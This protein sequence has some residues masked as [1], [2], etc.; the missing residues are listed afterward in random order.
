MKALNAEMARQ[1][2]ES[3]DKAFAL[4]IE[5]VQKEAETCLRAG[6]YEKAI[7]LIEE[8]EG[9]PAR[10]AGLLTKARDLQKRQVYDKLLNQAEELWKLVEPA[11]RFVEG[12]RSDIAPW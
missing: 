9:A 11:S 2:R 8:V 12:Q 6:E 7:A 10:L 1:Q 5:G 3:Q 4:R